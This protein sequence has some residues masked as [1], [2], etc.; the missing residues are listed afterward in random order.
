M[1]TGFS[2][3]VQLSVLI[4]SI[5]AGFFLGFVFSVFMFLNAFYGKNTIIVLIRD[6]L[7]FIFAAVFTFMFLLKYNAGTVRFYILAGILMGFCV[8]Y[9][10]PGA[11][12]GRL[13]RALNG[14]IEAKRMYVRQFFNKNSEKIK[15]R[16]S[17]I[18][19]KN[20]SRKAEKRRKK[21]KKIKTEAGKRQE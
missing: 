11:F 5:G 4:K 17:D 1:I 12:A 19:Q 6:I 8:F 14:K 18:K 16:V 10:F 7:Y 21:A 13:Y 20:S 15:V 9:L 3:T 2:H